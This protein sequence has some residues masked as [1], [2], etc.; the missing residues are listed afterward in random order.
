MKSLKTM[1]LKLI[2]NSSYYKDKFS[3]P[4]MN[5]DYYLYNLIYRKRKEKIENSIISPNDII[6]IS[7]LKI[8]TFF[9][10][11]NTYNKFKNISQ[12]IKKSEESK[13]VMDTDLQFIFKKTPIKIVKFNSTNMIRQNNTEKFVLPKELK[14][15]LIITPLSKTN[16]NFVKKKTNRKNK[17][18]EMQKSFT[19]VYYKRDEPILKNNFLSITPIRKNLISKSI[20]NHKI[21]EGTQINKDLF[22]ENKFV[23]T[24]YNSAINKYKYFSP[25]SSIFQRKLKK[26]KSVEYYY[27]GYI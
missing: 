15:P 6:P 9:K 20:T 23:N 21:S 18:K 16:T 14:N 17:L 1:H 25:K 22:N 24:K 19:T 7:N 26:I 10:D 8:K 11:P 27:Y 2:M 3:F 12:I 13:K 4:I 5:K